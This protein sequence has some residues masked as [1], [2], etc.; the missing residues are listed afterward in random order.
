M[1]Y[2]KAER[3]VVFMFAALIVLI[4]LS[5]FIGL[6]VVGCILSTRNMSDADWAT[7]YRREANRNYD[8]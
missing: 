8:R 3:K 7:I 1:L 2:D 6:N 5:A 4:S